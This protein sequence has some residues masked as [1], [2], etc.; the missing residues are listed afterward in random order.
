MLSFFQEK[1]LQHP[2]AK[3]ILASIILTIRPNTVSPQFGQFQHF[4]CALISNTFECST[5]S[6]TFRLRN[7]VFASDV[8]DPSEKR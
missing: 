4:L 3:I 2:T 8:L 7:I 1:I 6:F 5:G